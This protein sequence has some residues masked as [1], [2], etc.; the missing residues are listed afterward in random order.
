MHKLKEIANSLPLSPGC[1]IFK[2][3]EGQILYVGKSKCLKKRVATYFGKQ[4]DEKIAQLMRFA[5]DLC[6]KCV[7]TDVEALILEYCLIKQY[8]PPYNAK[9]RKDRQYWY[10]NIE[11][12]KILI[13]QE[14]GNISAGPFP[15]KEYAADALA[16]L[17]DY[18]PIPTCE[19]K[20]KGP[21]LRFHIKQCVAPCANKDKEYAE[22]IAFFKGDFSVLEK[23]NYRIKELVEEMAFEKAA[24]LQNQYENLYA[25]SNHIERMPPNLKGKNYY[26]SLKSRHDDSF[27]WVYMQDLCV[28][29]WMIFPN[30]EFVVFERE[31]GLKLAN[32]VLEI[33]A[34]RGF[35]EELEDGVVKI[36]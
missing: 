27:L 4:K 15:R 7:G 34:L 31:E 28:R 10:I 36:E 23:L 33:E 8:R 21:C 18:W 30:G 13:S 1:Y 11:E 29:A 26:I 9:M 2:D 16:Q 35:V 20:R 22:L 5:E 6:Y 17:G 25:L 3:G 19:A 32:A 24:H 14:K 12:P